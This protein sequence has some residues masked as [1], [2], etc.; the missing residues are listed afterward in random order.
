M[1][2]ENIDVNELKLIKFDE[3]YKVNYKSDGLKIKLNNVRS[4]FGLE[5]E[6]NNLILK[7][8]IENV[9]EREK[10]NIIHEKISSLLNKDVKNQLRDDN[11]LI[12]KIPKL[13]NKIITETIDINGYYN[14]YKIP[15][16]KYLNCEIYLDT[17]WK[18]N[19]RY[20]Y[21]WN[22]KKIYVI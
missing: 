11:V 8:S 21:K 12:C 16:N 5:N 17:I 9:K 4:L 6:Y 7:L 22:Y 13:K 2:L 19:D 18:F 1:E 20:Y 10:I 14:I 15:R 3:F